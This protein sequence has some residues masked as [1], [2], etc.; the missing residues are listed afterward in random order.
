[1]DSKKKKKGVYMNHIAPLSVVHQL[2][3]CAFLT[4]PRD[5][6]RHVRSAN[7]LPCACLDAFIL[8]GL[9]IR[10]LCKICFQISTRT[11]D[12][13]ALKENE[14][15]GRTSVPQSHPSISNNC[16]KPTIAYPS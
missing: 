1:M 11:S 6:V 3:P 14:F 10:P 9:T 13:D 8:F 5:T 2:V 12:S 7:R 15:L 16:R 4:E